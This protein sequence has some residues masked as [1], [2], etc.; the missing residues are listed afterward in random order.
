MTRLGGL[1]CLMPFFFVLVLLYDMCLW[2]YTLLILMIVMS[3][4]N[5]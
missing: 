5:E 3:C 2:F 4:L 1:V